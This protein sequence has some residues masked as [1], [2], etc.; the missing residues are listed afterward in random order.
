MSTR[1]LCLIPLAAACVGPAAASAQGPKDVKEEVLTK[2]FDDRRD[3][4]LLRRVS[5]NVFMH[6]LARVSFTVPKGWEE[7]PPQRL[8]RRI[9]PRV[10]TVLGSEKDGR[11]LVATLYWMPMTPGQKLSEWARDIEIGGEYG[12]E[13]ETLKAVYG[14]DRV[15]TPAKV[16]HGPFD[17][18]R[19]AI[20]GGKERAGRL[21][22][23]LYVF[24]VENPND[25][26]LL[27]ARIST[28]NA[29]KA[30]GEKYA[31]EVLNGYALASDPPKDQAKTPADADKP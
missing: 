15:S 28:P 1:R 24:E 3:L 11:S 2:P 26:W 22:G 21:D 5:D 19:I 29:E 4:T 17:V 6:E 18:Y 7:I 8:A 27:K 13:Y 10:S 16:R 20:T 23:T 25:R 12:E 14:K 30:A 9:D 31:A